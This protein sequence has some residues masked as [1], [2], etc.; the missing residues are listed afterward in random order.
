[1]MKKIV[2]LLLV[3][4]LAA[5]LQAGAGSGPQEDYITRYSGIAVAEM[6]RSG[7][8][9]SITLAQ[10][11]LESGSGRSR[12]ATE[13]NNHFGIKCHSKWK[14]KTIRADDDEKNE[15]FRAYGAA[16]DS[17]RDHSDFLR[18]NDRYKFL[19]DYPVTDYKSWAYGLKKAGYATDPSYAPKL[20]RYIEDYRLYEY[21]T[22]TVGEV[23]SSAPKGEILSLED[24]ESYPAE[25]PESPLKIEEATVYRP[26][27]AEE[28]SFSLSRTLYAKNGVPFLYSVEGE[29]YESIAAGRKLFLKEIL[30]IND[31]DHVE[32][33]L[34]GTV[35]YLEAKKKMAAKGLDKYIVG[36]DGEQLRDIAQRFAVRK[37]DLMKLNGLSE[38]DRLCEGDELLLR[39]VR[40][41]FRLWKR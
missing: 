23:Y 5:V 3:V 38:G 28:R 39:P 33:L 22:K 21:D 36:E 8:P 37:K 35:V 41:R 26:A 29:T 11:L 18:F 13:G 6:Y 7:V 15:C 24:G 12:L 34:P 4:L 9:A 16:E 40:K 32:P 27:Y 19:F 20:I 10:G 25:I 2:S 30:R 17:F 1:M 14:G 31:L